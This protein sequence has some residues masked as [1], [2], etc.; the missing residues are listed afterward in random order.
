[1]NHAINLSRSV[2]NTEEVISYLA[3][4]NVWSG[5][6]TGLTGN[7]Q[8]SAHLLEV[9]RTGAHSECRWVLEDTQMLFTYGKMYSHTHT[10]SFSTCGP[11]LQNDLGGFRAPQGPITVVWCTCVHSNCIVIGCCNEN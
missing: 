1:M 3:P 6:S 8:L 11:H 7:D 5:V 4:R 10:E 2:S 9:L